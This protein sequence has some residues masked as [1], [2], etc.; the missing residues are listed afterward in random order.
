MGAISLDTTAFRAQFPQF[1]SPTVFPN[2]KLSLY[3]SIASTYIYNN[4]WCNSR[5]TAFK[6]QALY[7]MT[8][9]MAAIQALIASGTTPNVTTQA[10]VDKVSL[11]IEPPPSLNAWQYWLQTTPYGQQLLALLQVNS[12]GGFFAGGF[13]VRAAFKR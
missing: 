11:T 3:F 13:P 9:H 1:V 8:A 4:S 2:D 10:T 5:V 12:A 6:T 7:L